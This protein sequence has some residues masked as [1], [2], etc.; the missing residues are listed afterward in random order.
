MFLSSVAQIGLE[1]SMAEAALE[2]WIL[3][4]RFSKCWEYGHEGSCLTILD[5][6]LAF[7]VLFFDKQVLFCF[8]LACYFQGVL[9]SVLYSVV[10][11]FRISL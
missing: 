1:L 8:V 2:L 7:L 4:P 6:L 9:S 10:C 3:L 5:Y 11:T